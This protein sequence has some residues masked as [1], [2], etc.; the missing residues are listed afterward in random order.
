[1]RFC[2]L[3]TI[4]YTIVMGILIVHYVTYYIVFPCDIVM[5]FAKI[6]YCDFIVAFSTIIFS[7]RYICMLYVS[8]YCVRSICAI[9]LYKT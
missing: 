2:V 6:I 7:V 3:C 9:V 4:I 8:G 1:M 5:V